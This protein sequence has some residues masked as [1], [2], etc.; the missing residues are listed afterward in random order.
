[1]ITGSTTFAYRLFLDSGKT[2]SRN[3]GNNDAGKYLCGK[4]QRDRVTNRVTR[5]RK[6]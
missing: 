2:G 5:I 4:Q 1:M 6:I 3:Q